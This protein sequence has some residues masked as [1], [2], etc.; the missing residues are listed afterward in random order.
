MVIT[1]S[2]STPT[3]QVRVLLVYN[4]SA[5]ILSENDENKQKEA[6]VGRLKSIAS[7]DLL[8]QGASTKSRQCIKIP[9]LMISS[10]VKTLVWYLPT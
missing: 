2:P 7:L 1:S 8:E 9:A 4:F 3:I 5:K 10:L 6:E